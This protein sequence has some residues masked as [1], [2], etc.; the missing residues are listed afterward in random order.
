MMCILCVFYC[1]EVKLKPKLTRIGPQLCE[2]WYMIIIRQK[3]L[4]FVTSQVLKEVQFPGIVT[5]VPKAIMMAQQSY[6]VVMF[7]SGAIS[8]NRPV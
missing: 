2:R 6:R 1:K 7:N 8:E 5:S 4:Y 3:L